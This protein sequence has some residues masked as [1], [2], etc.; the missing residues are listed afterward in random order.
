M[1]GK[2]KLRRGWWRAVLL[3]AVVL[4][5]GCGGGEEAGFDDVTS[6]VRPT[7]PKCP[8]QGHLAADPH[9]VQ[10]PGARTPEQYA[11]LEAQADGCHPVRFNPCEPIHYVVSDQMAPLGGARDIATAF[12]QLSEATGITFVNDG[13]SAEAAVTAFGRSPY[14]PDLYGQRWAPILIA[15]GHGQ[16][17]R[18]GPENPGGGRPQRVGDAYVS[19]YLVLNV[20]AVTAEGEPLPSGFGPGATWGRVIL[21]ELAHI[22]GLGHVSDQRQLMFAEL[23]GQTGRA[24]F[25]AGDRL[26][27]RII[28]KEGGCVTTPPPPTGP[29]PRPRP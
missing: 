11:F 7:L 24:E 27:L 2:A 16:S 17:V 18:L 29:G 20:D 28:G 12:Q 26:A 4:A 14:Q 1:A 21:H 8:V 5:G 23:G 19:G 9:G 15:W 3:A 25:S 10:R 13:P 6:N 22:L